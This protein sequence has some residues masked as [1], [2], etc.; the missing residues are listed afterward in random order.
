MP[1]QLRGFSGDTAWLDEFAKYKHP[2][3]VW[4]NLSFGMREASN[5]RPRKLITTTPRPLAV[6]KKIKAMATTVTVTGTSHENK[7]NLDPTW[8]RETILD[9]ENTRI[10]KQ[11]I[12]AQ[13]LEDFPGALWQRD[14]I[15]RNRL[16][17]FDPREESH[18]SWMEKWKYRL[19][20]VGVALDPA[21]T[22]TERAAEHGIIVGGLMQDG[23]G[24]ILEDLS[25]MATP[26]QAARI[27]IDAYDRWDADFCIGE[28]NNG[29]DWI[30][31]TIQAVASSMKRDGER[32]S[33]GVNYRSVHA[34]RGKRTRAE[35]IST[36]YEKNRVC[37]VGMFPELEDQMCSWDPLNG[38]KSPDRMDAAVWV[39]TALMGDDAK[40]RAGPLW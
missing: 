3:E 18:E 15:E 29:G 24:V 34:T 4:D 30:G 7:D 33:S 31:T 12:Y 28:V 20:R 16:P 14:T 27:M 37:H 35:P 32:T 40:G 39:L 17:A 19:K 9:Y 22:S 5:D 36:L 25:R 2:Q 8:Y 23:R 10:G 11:E 13:I 1:D 38:D 21:S 6:L 26:A